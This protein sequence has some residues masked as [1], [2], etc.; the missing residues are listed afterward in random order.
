MRQLC[1]TPPPHTVAEMPSPAPGT[2]L[3]SFVALCIHPLPQPKRLQ[4]PFV[5]AA[6]ILETILFG[7][8]REEWKRVLWVGLGLFPFASLSLSL[9]A[10]QVL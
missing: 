7:M 5:R 10:P 9:P 1:F 4:T 6:A 8:A 3:Q 2:G